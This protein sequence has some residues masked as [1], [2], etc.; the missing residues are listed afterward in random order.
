MHETGVKLLNL[1]FREGESICVSPS[2]YGYHSIDLKETFKDEITLLNT[3]FR[4]GEPAESCLEKC[5]TNDLK[6]VALNPINGWRDDSS[7]YKYRNFLVEIDFG[8]LSEQ[9]EHI[10][11]LEMPYSAVVFSG[12]KSLHFLI[13]LSTDLPDEKTWRRISEWILAIV[14]IADQNCKNPSRSIRVPGAKRDDKY[15]ELREFVGPTDNAVLGVWLQRY[16]HLMPTVITKKP[17]TG[18]RRFPKLKLWMTKALLGEFPTDKGRNKTWFT[19]ACEFVLKGFSLEETEYL[20]SDFFIPDRDF[21]EPEWKRALK[22]A[23]EYMDKNR[24]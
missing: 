2:K 9:L 14:T 3:R 17:F 24:K 4:D 23:F 11:K 18:N 20:L 22:S 13:S 1:M 8:E 10:K 6:L 5:S 16:A 15:Q 21:K 12:G 7:C 19:I